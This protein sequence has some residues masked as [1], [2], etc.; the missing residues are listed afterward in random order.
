MVISVLIIHSNFML[1]FDLFVLVVVTSYIIRNMNKKQIKELEG[2]D[3]ACGKK[4][5]QE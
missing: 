3:M 4:S 5:W 1:I 2:K